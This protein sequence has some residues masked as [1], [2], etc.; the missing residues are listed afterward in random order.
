MSVHAQKFWF[1]RLSWIKIWRCGSSGARNENKT[2]P[3]CRSEF[4]RFLLF[5]CQNS[6]STLDWVVRPGNTRKQRARYRLRVAKQQSLP[7]CQTIMRNS[8]RP[9]NDASFAKLQQHCT[10]LFWCVREKRKKER[11]GGGWGKE[12]G[13]QGSRIISITAIWS[14][15]MATL[16]S[17][18][19]QDS[20]SYPVS[21]KT[22]QRTRSYTTAVINRQSHEEQA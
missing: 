5:F 12:T 3:L 11:K 13:A 22:V 20:G 10:T 8:L 15:H 17:W 19:K 21:H 9:L 18:E 14:R 16:Y 6:R 7:S 4:F 1:W 2:M